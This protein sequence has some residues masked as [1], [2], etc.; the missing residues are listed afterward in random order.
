MKNVHLN[1]ISHYRRQFKIISEISVRFG[2]YLI[3]F[4]SRRSYVIKSFTACCKI[5]LKTIQ[6][7]SNMFG[8]VESSLILHVT[9]RG[10]APPPIR[11]RSWQTPTS[12]W[13]WSDLRPET[14]GH[15]HSSGFRWRWASTWWPPLLVYS[16]LPKT[17]GWQRA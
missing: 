8:S 1:Q 5:A 15:W 16:C 6:L 2:W 14:R 9:F 10:L 13:I 4:F 7:G 3:R 12:R 17:S 11:H